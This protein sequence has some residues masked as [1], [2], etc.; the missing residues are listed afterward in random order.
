MTDE[1][2]IRTLLQAYE[3]AIRSKDADAVVACYA[4]DAIGYDLAPPLAIDF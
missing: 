4:Q 2:D 1:A 3:N